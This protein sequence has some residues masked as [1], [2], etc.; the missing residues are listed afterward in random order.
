MHSLQRLL[1]RKAELKVI[2]CEFHNC[3][4]IVDKYDEITICKRNC[5]KAKSIEK[6]FE[7][8]GFVI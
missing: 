4:A 2:R 3:D 8:S 7:C 1:H 6:R 5:K